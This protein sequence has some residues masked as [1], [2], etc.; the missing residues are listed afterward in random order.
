MNIFQIGHVGLA[1]PGRHARRFPVRDSKTHG[2]CGGPARGPLLRPGQKACYPPGSRIGGLPPVLPRDSASPPVPRVG[3]LARGG[4][5]VGA[6]AVREPHGTRAPPLGVAPS[7]RPIIFPMVDLFCFTPREVWNSVSRQCTAVSEGWRGRRGG[8]GW[9]ASLTP[10]M[11]AGRVTVPVN[12][13]GRLCTSPMGGGC[14]QAG[15]R[16][17]TA[18]RG[19]GEVTALARG[20][21]ADSAGSNQTTAEPSF[22]GTPAMDYQMWPGYLLG[23]FFAALVFLASLE[24]AAAPPAALSSSP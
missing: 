22:A 8:A 21:P 6:L 3:R 15:T 17:G 11:L 12:H 9:V 2:S 20:C 7:G 24:L 1:S 10:A 4:G 14:E 18:V 5:C 16:S 13:V 19:K 23:F